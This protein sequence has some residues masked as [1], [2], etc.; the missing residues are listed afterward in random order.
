MG[1]LHEDHKIFV[2]I[3]RTIFFKSEMFQTKVVEE[4]KPHI[5]Y[6][7]TFFSENRAVCEIIWKDITERDRPQM[8]I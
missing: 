3:S 5:L 4:I 6:S 7:I 1:T 8:T 2:I